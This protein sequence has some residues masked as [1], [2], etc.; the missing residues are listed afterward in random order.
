MSFQRFKEPKTMIRT[1][2]IFLILANLSRWFL[3]P[4]ARLSESWTDGFTGFPYG[5]TIALII[6]G[7]WKNGRRRRSQGGIV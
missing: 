5:I 7:I 1:G 6:T 4:S 3:H 2:F